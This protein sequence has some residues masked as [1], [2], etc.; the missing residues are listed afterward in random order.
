[1]L[2]LT[3]AALL[4]LAGCVA[5]RF[6]GET[7]S[8]L[9]STPRKIEHKITNP[10]RNDARLAALW[11]G[12]ATFLV[13]IDDRFV[14]TDPVFTST[15]GM[16]T[17]RLVEPGLD[18]ANLPKLDA[19]LISHLHFDHLSLGSLEMI[20]KKVGTLIL[21]REGTTYLTDFAFPAIELHTWQ[22][23]EKDGLRITAAPIDHL[24]FRY[25]ADRA[26]M[27]HA[28]TGYLIEYHGIRVYFSGD[29]AYDGTLFAEAGRRFPAI[30]LALLPISPLEP[31]ELMRPLHMNPTDAVR[32]FVDLG[33]KRMIP[34]HYDTFINPEDPPGGALRELGEATNAM[35]SGDRQVIPLAIGE[36][37]VLIPR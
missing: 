32:A 24:G 14:L 13:Q 3:F 18:P 25:G 36:Q 2:A 16:L 37:R 31:R 19:V 27:Q 20:E 12:H 8:T 7:A 23:W 30:D 10:T 22:T 28:F 35:V 9:V 33:A 4:A 5:S 11:I 6:L 34:M 1:M 21:P 15:V 29:T 26:W 17:K